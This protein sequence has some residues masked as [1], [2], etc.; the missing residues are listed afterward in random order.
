MDTDGGRDFI[1]WF[2]FLIR[3]IHGLN[4]TIR[5]VFG[6]R[7][8]LMNIKTMQENLREKNLLTSF[9][10]ENIE[11]TSQNAAH[12]LKFSLHPLRDHL[13]LAYVGNITIG[14]TPQEFRVVFDTDLSNLWMPSIYCYSPACHTH[15][16]FNPHSST[17]SGLSASKF[18]L[19]YG[20]GRIT[21]F[22]GYDTIQVIG[23]QKLSQA[24]P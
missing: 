3:S 6:E 10:E 15:K 21:G 13:D 4:G 17:T 8:P 18:N 1:E 2:I 20:S 16:L 5:E 12:D 7:I 22:L 9:L 11:D 23:N 19:T 24:W 14:I